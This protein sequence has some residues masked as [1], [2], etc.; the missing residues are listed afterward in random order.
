M[1]RTPR[2]D[3]LSLPYAIRTLE[4]GREVLLDRGYR[5][6]YLRK[7][8]QNTVHVCSGQKSMPPYSSTDYFYI[9]AVE[10]NPQLRKKLEQIEVQFCRGDD[11]RGLFVNLDAV[12]PRVKKAPISPNIDMGNVVRLFPREE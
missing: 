12:Y 10:G 6:R 4:C 2:R 7:P 8:G 3:L 5:A 9:G 1:S 11:V